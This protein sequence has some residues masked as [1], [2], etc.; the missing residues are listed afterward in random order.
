METHVS[1]SDVARRLGIAPRTISDLFYSR[2]LR[3]DVCPIVA[4][5]RL[6][7][8]DYVEEIRAVLE[9]R[10]ALVNAEAV[11]AD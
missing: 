10:G 8:A 5:R 11:Q 9:Q 3:D 2:E 1:V 4:G 7:P 6:I